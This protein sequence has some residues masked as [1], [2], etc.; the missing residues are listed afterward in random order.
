MPPSFESD[1]LNLYSFAKLEQIPEGQRVEID[2]LKSE[3]HSELNSKR[4]GSV[5]KSYLQS[6]EENDSGCIIALNEDTVLGFV[7]FIVQYPVITITYL[8][9]AKQFRRRGVATVLYN[10]LIEVCGTNH[11]TA[12]RENP[13]ID[14]FALPGDLAAKS[15]F[16]SVGSKG[17]LIIMSKSLDG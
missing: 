17:N 9:V 15:F 12:G 5:L 3:E 8:V 2:G 1:R 11:P 7:E 4:G 13:R 10:R 6:H 14:S 16:E